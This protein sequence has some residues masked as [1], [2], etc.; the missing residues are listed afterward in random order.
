MPYP[1][2]Q[3]LLYWLDPLCRSIQVGP[4]HF[5]SL[6]YRVLTEFVDENSEQVVVCYWLSGELRSEKD[7]GIDRVAV[8][9]CWQDEL[10]EVKK[11]VFSRVTTQRIFSVQSSRARKVWTSLESIIIVIIN[12]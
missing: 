4:I 3:W 8:R 9:T 10:E 11:S 7:D 1:R 12:H 5:K 2:V 6:I